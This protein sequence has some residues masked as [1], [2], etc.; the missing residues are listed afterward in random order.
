MH[1]FLSFSL[2]PTPTQLWIRHLLGV[3]LIEERSGQL[4]IH[5]PRWVLVCFPQAYEQIE[6][7]LLHPH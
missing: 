4:S 5:I 6:H 3:E 2:T 1:P 7:A